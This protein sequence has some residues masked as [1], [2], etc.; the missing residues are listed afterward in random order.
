MINEK[1]YKQIKNEHN[2]NINTLNELTNLN[3]NEDLNNKTRNNQ[4][5]QVIKKDDEFR[6]ILDSARFTTHKAK[7][8]S[9]DINFDK[10]N[11]LNELNNRL[12]DLDLTESDD[13]D[14]KKKQNVI[15]PYKDW[16]DVVTNEMRFKSK[17]S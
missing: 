9:I 17:Y 8:T 4:P 7:N 15:D 6:N 11:K 13:I 5:I 14:L 12:N 3:V 16:K 2:S 10:N 1:F